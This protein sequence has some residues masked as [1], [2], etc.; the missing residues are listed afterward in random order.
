MGFLARMVCSF[1]VSESLFI[2]L[3][4]SYG[5]WFFQ[6]QGEFKFTRFILEEFASSI[7]IVFVMDLIVKHC[8]T[9]VL[10]RLTNE[11]EG[12]KRNLHKW[13]RLPCG[14]REYQ[15]IP[16]KLISWEA[17]I[18]L[19]SRLVLKLLNIR[20][21]LWRLEYLNLMHVNLISI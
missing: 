3:P 15:S 4:F 17:R 2:F 20:R 13:E 6:G 11:T 5:K 1:Q 10:I 8:C 18:W 7:M 9:N 12:L 19:Y 21:K 14:A 16:W